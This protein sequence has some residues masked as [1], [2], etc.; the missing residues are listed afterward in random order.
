MSVLKALGAE[1]IRTPTEAAF[2]SPGTYT[3]TVAMCY[4]QCNVRVYGQIVQVG[5]TQPCI[6]YTLFTYVTTVCVYTRVRPKILIFHITYCTVHVETIVS[7]HMYMYNVKCTL[8]PI[9]ISCGRVL[10]EEEGDPQLS[11]PGPVPE[12]RQPPGSL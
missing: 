10:E 11:H 7:L 1:V 12:C 2:N 6:L 8:C 5:Y 4:L 9:R 3:C